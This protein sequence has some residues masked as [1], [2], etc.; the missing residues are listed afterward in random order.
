MRF[1]RNATKNPIK[2]QGEEL[3][4]HFSEENNQMIN[5]YVK[6]C[7]APLNIREIQSKTTVRYH[8]T[9]VWMTFIKKIRDHKRWWGGWG[10]KG[11]LVHCWGCKLVSGSTENS[12]E[13][14]QKNKRRPVIWSSS[15][16]SGHSYGENETVISKRHLNPYILCSILYNSQDV[17]TVFLLM[18]EW[19]KKMLPTYNEIL[20]SHTKKETLSSA[21]TWTDL[22][23]TVLDEM[24]SEKDKY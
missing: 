5:W 10:E 1:S 15:S 17:E 7:S 12:V 9:P 20:F 19:I 24:P 2:K 14:P 22:Q 18:E 16:T 3:N 23:G 8:L 11:T 4:R 21:T 6:R 13:I